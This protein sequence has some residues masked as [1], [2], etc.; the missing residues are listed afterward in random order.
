M[1]QTVY[2]AE[3]R[4]GWKVL[5]TPGENTKKKKVPDFSRT[6]RVGGRNRTRTCDPIDV[7]DVL[8]QLS[9]QTIYVNRL[10]SFFV[11]VTSADTQ[12]AG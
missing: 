5:N 10:L 8:Y 2:I 12:R 9:Q 7:N 1:E 3:K 4:F 11:R 6:V